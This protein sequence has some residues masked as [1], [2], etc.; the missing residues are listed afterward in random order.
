MGESVSDTD[1]E[2]ISIVT[3]KRDVINQ[4]DFDIDDFQEKLK[5]KAKKAGK[6]SQVEIG[7]FRGIAV[8]DLSSEDV[9][10]VRYRNLVAGNA[11]VAHVLRSSIACIVLAERRF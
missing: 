3:L 9:A 8:S 6:M 2:N 1:M 10:Q 5:K 11:N 4:T 7:S